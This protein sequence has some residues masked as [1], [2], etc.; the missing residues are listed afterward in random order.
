MSG[1]MLKENIMAG[2]P[3]RMKS[4]NDYVGEVVPPCGEFAPRSASITPPWM[5][6]KA[7]A[8]SANRTSLHDEIK[9]FISYMRLTEDERL[10]RK[11]LISRFTRLI[12]KLDSASSMRCVGSSVT[13]LCF[14]TSD[15]DMV[16]T[17]RPSHQSFLGPSSPK[18][19]LSSLVSKID[20]S[21]FAS[22][23]ESILNASV[24][25]LRITDAKTGLQIDLTSDNGH[26]VRATE[27]VETWLNCG[28]RRV[29]KGLV[30][31]LKLFLAMRRLGTTYTG[32][33][34]SYL[35]FW[36][37]VAWVKLELPDLLSGKKSPSTTQV[38][39][40]NSLDDLLSRMGTLSL[41]GP[42]SQVYTR[43]DQQTDVKHV[44]LGVAL[45]SILKFY[46]ESFDAKSTKI[47]ISSDSV[48]YRYKGTFYSVQPFLLSINDPAALVN[49][50]MGSKAYAFKH[51]QATFREAY[52]KL[53]LAEGRNMKKS[54][55][56]L[57]Y[58]L[59]GDYSAFVSKREA[60]VQ[61]WRRSR[62]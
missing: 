47:E 20:T 62:N 22:K 45:K 34:N 30:M 6:I 40:D 46:G 19:R 61:K 27:A 43:D 48:R 44:D 55:G 32:G 54:G 18:Y 25:L 4:Y 60:M 49:D 23:I 11:D 13:G 52:R 51:V 59:D 10:L 42:P 39:G 17:F 9:L 36:M 33:I 15:I 56:T 14:P 35:L 16:I 58:I 53:E 1:R 57:A 28:E 12:A 5:D 38:R 21:R 8:G 41:Q 50:D 7:E 29:I 31:V 2:L 26:G 3:S 37:V 24:P